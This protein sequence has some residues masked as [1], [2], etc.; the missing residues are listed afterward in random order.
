M[1][2][3]HLLDLTLREQVTTSALAVGLRAGGQQ[4]IAQ[5]RGHRLVQ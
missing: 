2:I 4:P 5:M 3:K 1:K